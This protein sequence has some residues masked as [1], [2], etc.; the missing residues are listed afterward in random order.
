MLS[1]R[2]IKQR[3]PL[4]RKGGTE[5]I[6]FPSAAILAQ[7]VMPL[8]SI[9]LQSPLIGQRSSAQLIRPDIEDIVDGHHRIC[10]NG[11][12]AGRR[13]C[14]ASA[15]I[16]TA[17]MKWAEYLEIVLQYSFGKAGFAMA[18]KVVGRIKGIVEIEH[19]NNM[20]TVQLDPIALP[21]RYVGSGAQAY[22]IFNL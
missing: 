19:S 5:R 18:A 8:P 6:I 15:D 7:G 13:G 22:K 11:Y 2:R 16:E 21:H 1:L 3:S 10:S 12:L 14:L 17:H 4:R 20:A 9:L